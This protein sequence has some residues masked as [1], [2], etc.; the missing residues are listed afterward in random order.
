[1]RVVVAPDKFKG[2]LTAEQVVAHV[3]AGLRRVVPD[4]EVVGVP[5]ADGGEGTVDAALAAGYRAVDV[6]V[7]GPLGVPV[8]ARY[9]ARDDVAVVE[10]AAASG[11]ALTAADVDAARTSGTAGT[12]ELLAHATGGGATT[13]VLGVGGSASTDGGAGMLRA[14]GARLLDDV[15]APVGPGGAGLATLASADLAPAR[16]RL[17]GVELVLATDV[18]NPLLGPQGAAAVYGPQKGADAATVVE[19]EAGLTRLVRVL[20]AAEEASRPGAGAAGGLGF[21]AFLLGARRRVGV[22]VVLE[23]VGFADALAGADLVVTGEGSLDAQSLHGKTPVGV[24]G[25]ARAVGVPTVA[26]AGRRDVADDALRAAGIVDVLALTD[27]E[28]DVQR[29]IAEAGPLL[30]D[31]AEQLARRHLAGPASS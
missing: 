5:V 8:T 17:A 12:G 28:P 2:S 9:A 24:A 18:D 30:E 4:V 27:V 25:A 31:V 16:E 15:G 22:E 1:M 6:E 26:V 29:C 7:T 23:L 14:L 3:A 10:M 21:G 19:L 20:G 11:L 13:V